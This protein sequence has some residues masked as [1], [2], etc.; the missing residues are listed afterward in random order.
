MGT[1]VATNALLERKGTKHAFLVTRGHRDVLEIGSQQRPDIFAL[2]IRKAGVLYDAVV[3]ID[4]RVTPEYYDEAPLREKGVRKAIEGDL[5]EGVGG[6]LIRVLEK[7]NEDTTRASLQ[8]LRDQGYTTVAVCLAHSFLYAK[9][10]ERIQEIAQELGFEHIS[11]SSQVGARMVKMVAR[12]GSASADAYLT[13]ETHKYISGFAAGFEGSNL[14][15]LRCEFMQSDGGLVN[16]KGFSGMKG[17]LSGP[18]GGL[19]GYARTSYDG[20]TPVVGFDMGG[21]S[22]QYSHD[23]NAALRA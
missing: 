7:L 14:D 9:H 10:E 8:Q 21:T 6:E 13:P 1:T 22:S 19:V 3:E 17:I 11:L 12:G 2:D 23:R 4:E 20:K 18:A 16:Y 5:V 15:G